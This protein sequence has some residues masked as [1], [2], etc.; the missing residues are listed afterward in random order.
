MKLIIPMAGR[1]TRLRPHTHVTP[2]PLLPVLGITIVERIV[3]T[4]V[5]LVPGKISDAVF[6]LGDFPAEVQEKLT[7]M[8]TK[9]GIGAQ[10]GVQKEALGTAH[11]VSCAEEHLEGELIVIFA[12]TLF[13]T[14]EA[15]NT[16]ADIVAYV[17]QV[18]DPRRFGVVARDEAGN[19]SELIEK[20]NH[21]QF[22]EALI[23]IYYIKNGGVFRKTILYMMQHKLVGT[24]GEYEVTDALD[25]MMKAG[26]T[27]ETATVTDWLDCGTL[28][29]LAETTQF[30]L[31]R[32]GSQISG[33]LINTT[34]IEP[35]YIGPGVTVRDS[36][37]GP[38]TAIES[39]AEVNDSVVKNSIIF[40][41]AG[42][43][44]V[45]MDRSFIGHS[46]V[47]KQSAFSAN[48]G[49][50]TVIEYLS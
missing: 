13:Y 8:C 5:D 30:I 18:E 6:V 16:E 48:I 37:V 9:L 35:V 43:A 44:N 26:A 20:P 41:N 22:K 46:A 25:M 19:V 15:L 36:V 3:R 28:P 21:D 38:Y 2:K 33:D 23:G 42:V 40:S 11:A 17:K 50:H 12:D 45:V 24:R 34:I 14:Q 47:I 4:F 31:D 7:E 27:L 49:D 1:G 32:E 29:A 39:G 10:F